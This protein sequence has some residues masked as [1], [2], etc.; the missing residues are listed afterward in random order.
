MIHPKALQQHFKKIQERQM[1][2]KPLIPNTVE[3]TPLTSIQAINISEPTL[4]K[5]DTSELQKE[6]LEVTQALTTLKQTLTQTPQI[7]P[8]T[9][10]VPV[11]VTINEPKNISKNIEDTPYGY[12]KLKIENKQDYNPY[13]Y[14]SG[15]LF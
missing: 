7:E 9:V 2:L 1:P 13:G 3:A 14:Y 6:L 10:T 5:V 8:E 4:L 15:P 12:S 11:S